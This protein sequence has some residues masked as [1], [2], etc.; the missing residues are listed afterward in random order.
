MPATLLIIA[1]FL[2][3][4]AIFTGA[5]DNFLI[6]ETL[7]LLLALGAA[8]VYLAWKFERKEKISAGPLGLSI[9][10]F[11]AVELLSVINA[12]FPV[13]SIHSAVVHFCLLT[14]FV[15]ALETGATQRSR[16]LAFAMAAGYAASFYGILQAF[17][18]DFLNWLTGFGGRVHSSLGNPNFYAGWLAVFVP[19]ALERSVRT[20]KFSWIL[21]TA[22]FTVNMFLTGTR[23]A[24]VAYA[25]S[26]VYLFF[27]LGL[28]RV[29]GVVP[30]VLAAAVLTGVFFGGKAVGYV[31]RKFSPQEQSVKERVFKWR[32]ALEMVKKHPMLG[33]GAGNMKVNFALYQASVRKQGW[34]QVLIFDSIFRMRSTS[35]SNV[36]NEYFQVWAETGTLGLLAFLSIFAV[37]FIFF[38]ANPANAG[39]TGAVAGFL[40]FSLS[41]FPLRIPPTALYLFVFMGFA[42][43]LPAAPASAPAAEKKR[44]G[45]G[46]AGG[47]GANWPVRL[48]LFAAYVFVCWKF[49]VVPLAADVYRQRGDEAA[50]AGDFRAALNYYE[51]SVKMDYV[52]SERTAFDLGEIYRKLGM[53]D[54]ALSAYRISVDIRN[55]GEVYNCIGN[56]HWL[57]SD[58]RAA[59]E[60]WKTA[61]SLGL[62]TEQDEETVRRNIGYAKKLLTPQTQGDRHQNRYL[63]PVNMG[64]KK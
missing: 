28:H 38:A 56:C 43:S 8:A 17:G 57:K 49:A 63:S 5:K 52:H 59:V 54:N 47:A 14:A 37:Y 19:I 27:A 60:N 40:V 24:W 36:H 22:L 39:Y 42:A 31:A 45:F 50:A 55:Y 25:V 1:V 46:A 34:G 48:A 18:V 62:P 30:V 44:A 4:L 10:A 3:P 7:T 20:K 33:V 15:I 9:T 29:K 16:I 53:I 35:E 12:K 21:L 61:E 51:K 23:G 64:G 2:T 41:N 32:T 11:I 13:L 26:A 6:K 58:P